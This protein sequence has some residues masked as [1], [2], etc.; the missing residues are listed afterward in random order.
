MPTF[1]NKVIL[2]KMVILTILDHFGPV[3]FRQY[4][5]HSLDSDK[6]S[7]LRC[8]RPAKHL[9][10]KPCETK[11]RLFSPL[12]LVG[13]QEWVLQVPKRGQFH[14]CH[15]CDTETLRFACPRSTRETDGIAAKLSRCG[16]DSEALRPNMPLS[17]LC[18]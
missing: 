2:T 15:S 6:D 4:R 12:L 10:P 16:I 1:W 3:H 17:G 5:G 8:Q 9:K 7:N 11:P 13:N 18:S 14:T